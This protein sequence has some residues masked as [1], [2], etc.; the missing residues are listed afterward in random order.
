MMLTAAKPKPIELAPRAIAFGAINKYRCDLG[1]R[2][3][4]TR[5]KVVP[6]G[7][8]KAL[9]TGLGE[10]ATQSYFGYCG[11]GDAGSAIDVAPIVAA[12]ADLLPVVGR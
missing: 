12:R 4:A 1:N 5:M 9:T 6:P 2:A 3:R 10:W 8:T 11:P 7:A